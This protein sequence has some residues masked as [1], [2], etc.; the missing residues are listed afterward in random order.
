MARTDVT[1][2][3]IGDY[4]N[5]PVIEV[6][7]K[8]GQRVEKDSALITLESEKATMEVPAPARLLRR[9]A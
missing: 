5:V 6:L 9:V 4:E 2:P 7:V 8:D 3:D 1:I